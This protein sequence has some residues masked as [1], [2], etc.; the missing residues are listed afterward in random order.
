M[1][2][3][4]PLFL[5]IPSSLFVSAYRLT[6]EDD[7]EYNAGYFGETV[8]LE[9]IEG[10]D[11]FEMGLSANESLKNIVKTLKVSDDC[12][13]CS[14]IPSTRL[15]NMLK[16]LEGSSSLEELSFSSIHCSD[17]LDEK[18]ERLKAERAEKSRGFF[19]KLFPKQIIVPEQPKEA[20]GFDLILENGLQKLQFPSLKVL[21]IFGT[22]FT[23]AVLFQY[24]RSKAGQNLT[25][26]SSAFNT[27]LKAQM[28]PKLAGS[29][30][31]LQTL[32]IS[33]IF[34]SET[35]G[36]RESDS[37]MFFA[38]LAEFS[39]L[40]HLVFTSRKS[41]RLPGI[42][43][44]FPEDEK[45][46]VKFIRK[47]GNQLKTIS[48]EPAVFVD[49]LGMQAISRNCKSLTDLELVWTSDHERS[50]P[51]FDAVVKVV[52]N[53]RNLL[54]LR[55]VNP[56]WKM[57]EKTSLNQHASAFGNISLTFD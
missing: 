13:S 23:P 32:V 41:A 37:S 43:G 18:Y 28:M 53:C 35:L 47:R 17:L 29:M 4:S 55:L 5:V 27:K 56:K 12:T 14:S 19:S 36:H 40:E 20:F 57:A 24:L 50:A 30:P 26:F 34:Q 52:Q 42:F 38:G 22:S 44:G 51:F 21:Q 49:S 8:D 10:I 25:K 6:A 45:L 16:S 9:F 33:D 48:I 3:I 54:N 15:I 39:N 11:D 31:N 7:L 2:I 46:F 1:K